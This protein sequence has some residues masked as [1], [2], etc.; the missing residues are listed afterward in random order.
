MK[1]VLGKI[2]QSLGLPRGTATAEAGTFVA[3]GTALDKPRYFIVSPYKT[4]TTTVGNALIT[5]GAGRHEMTFRRGVLNLHRAD[6]QRFAKT[7]K[8]DTDTRTWISQNADA[9]RQVLAPVMSQL[10]RYDVFSDAP[11]GHGHVHCCVLKAALPSAR[12]IWV[13][14]PVSDWLDSVRAW[15]ISHPETYPKYTDWEDQPKR[16]RRK[17]RRKRIRLYEHF[18][19]LAEAYPDDCLELSMKDLRS[20][21]KLA[22]FCGVQVPEGAPAAQNVNRPKGDL[23]SNG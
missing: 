17:L 11:F 1:R 19:Q 6:F 9:A 4:A 10:L 16:R 20:W 5:L 22:A 18:T 23:P 12:F 13:D 2:V 8:K 14:R 7:I 21:D 15:E 3:S